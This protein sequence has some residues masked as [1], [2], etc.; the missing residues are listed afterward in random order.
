MEKITAVIVAGGEGTRIAGI[1]EGR[2][3]S[4][5]PIGGR[6]VLSRHLDLIGKS[7][8]ASHVY[9]V[10]SGL[11]KTIEEALSAEFA[12]TDNVS[13]IAEPSP[14]GSAG[15]LGEI[16]RTAEGPVLIVFGDV[17]NNLSFSELLKF[18]RD[19]GADATVVV[20]MTDHPEDSDLVEVNPQN[21]VE[22]IL[23]KPHTNVQQKESLGITGVFMIS[24]A[25]YRE[26]AEGFKDLVRDVIAP[27][28]NGGRRVFALWSCSY[29]KDIGTPKRYAQANL[30]WRLGKIDQSV[31][32][33]R[34]RAAF[35]DRD[36]TIIEFEHRMGRIEDV[37]LRPG[38]ARAIRKINESGAL[39]I[40]VTNQPA[41]AHG[42]CSLEDVERANDYIESELRTQGAS[43]DG[44][45]VCPHHPT[46]QSISRRLAYCVEC[47]CRKPQPGLVERAMQSFQIDMT[48][49]AVFGDSW[50]DQ[51]LAKRVGAAAYIVN[52]SETAS[53]EKTVIHESLTEAVDLWLASDTLAWRASS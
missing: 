21:C 25:I 1:A 39:A 13:V 34:R 41:I 18:H 19:R 47:T 15:Y 51:Q 28:V 32:I 11:S 37:K 45:Y 14:L 44:W 52:S 23:L 22:R 8:I 53:V 10:T 35:I 3:K 38:V 16:L 49:S 6:S 27:A 33:A 46:S 7:G 48:R 17:V 50:R 36:G 24:D 12:E 4:L 2:P 29:F 5:M 42:T 31:P 9:V 26:I 30:D 20:R 43:L 40:V